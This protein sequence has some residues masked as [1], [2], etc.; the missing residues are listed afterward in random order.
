[1]DTEQIRNRVKK[2]RDAIK[3]AEHRVQVAKERLRLAQSL[4]SHADK[5][6]WTNN[7]GDGQFRVE[8]QYLRL[9]ERRRIVTCTR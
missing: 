1:M 5:D 2:A 9:A 7:D 6:S 4:C 8:R 3:F